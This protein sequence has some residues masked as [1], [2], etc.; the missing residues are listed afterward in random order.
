MQIPSPMKPEDFSKPELHNLM[1]G[2]SNQ[3][4]P[5]E[6]GDSRET[7]SDHRSLIKKT[8][9]VSHRLGVIYNNQDRDAGRWR[10]SFL[11][12]FCIKSSKAEKTALSEHRHSQARAAGSRLSVDGEESL[13][14]QGPNGQSASWGDTSWS[15]F[16]DKQSWVSWAHSSWRKHSLVQSP[17]RCC[18]KRWY[19]KKW[20]HSKESI[21]NSLQ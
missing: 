14:N 4:S 12:R 19:R 21:I 15:E 20:S 8:R 7:A 18:A 11:D 9:D 3:R 17:D 10:E 16:T 6:L 1:K 5:G 13:H 2:F